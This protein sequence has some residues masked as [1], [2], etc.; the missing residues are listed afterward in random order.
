MR[1]SLIF[2]LNAR[3]SRHNETEKC[4]MENSFVADRTLTLALDR[5]SVPVPCLK[6]Q[7]L[8]KQ[9]EAPRGLYILK[10]GKATLVMNAENGVEVM[11]LTIGPGAILGIPAVVT[12]EPYTLSAKACLGSDIAFVELS[13]FEEMMQ[14]KPSLFPLVLAILATEIR[15]ARIALIGLM[16]NLK[17]DLRCVRLRPFVAP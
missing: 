16:T 4:I 5:T 3:I 13:D 9:G 6:E 17:A 11:H 1:R 12:K 10:S 14:A 8:F 7:T 2:R 15:A